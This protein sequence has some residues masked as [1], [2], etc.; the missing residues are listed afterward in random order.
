MKGPD[1]ERLQ[2]HFKALGGFILGTSGQNRDGVDGEYGPLTMAAVMV[3]ENRAR[4]PV[5]GIFDDGDYEALIRVLNQGFPPEDEEDSSPDDTG[6]VPDEP[7]PENDPDDDAPE[8]NAKY[9]RITGSSVNI[10]PEPDTNKAALTTLKKGR[11]ADISRR[12]EV[13]LA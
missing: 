2:G 10:R 3:F 13:W 5:D 12:H 9:V 4:L 8:A 11:A 6:D 1:V 7:E